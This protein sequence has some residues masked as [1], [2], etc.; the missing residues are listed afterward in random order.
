MMIA[1]VCN[2]IFHAWLRYIS[3]D[4]TNAT[5]HDIPQLFSAET[6]EAPSPGLNI[7]MVVQERFL[8]VVI[9]LLMWSLL[10]LMGWYL[11]VF[12]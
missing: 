11:V 5:W 2:T 3:V 10:A 7:G 1:K 6:Y 8:V 4:E 9:L 12:L